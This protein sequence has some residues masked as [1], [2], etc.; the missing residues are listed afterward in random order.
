MRVLVVIFLMMST[1]VFADPGKGRTRDERKKERIERQLQRLQN[2]KD[3]RSREQKRKD[4]NVLMFMAV[5]AALVIKAM[6]EE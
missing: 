5:S 6:S 4:R 2:P 3:Q 1:S